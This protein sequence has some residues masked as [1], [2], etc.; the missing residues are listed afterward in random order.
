MN[1]TTIKEICQKIL[2]SDI[3]FD[4]GTQARVRTDIK[5][6]QA[7]IESMK[8]GVEFPPLDV[9]NDGTSPK[10]I[11]GDGFHRLQSHMSFRPNKPISCRVHFG[12]LEDAQ[13]FAITANKTHGLR[14][15]NEDKRKAVK[16]AL[17]HQKCRDEQMSSRA[18]AEAVGVHHDMVDRIRSELGSV[19]GFRQLNEKR[20]GKDGKSYPARRHRF[21]EPPEPDSNIRTNA[22]GK[23]VNT[24]GY[25]FRY[26]R[27]CDQCDL[28]S[29]ETGLCARDDSPQPSWT[30]ACDDWH[31]RNDEFAPDTEPAAQ[32]VKTNHVRE[33]R[34]T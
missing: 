16:M 20:V 32:K 27:R 10:Y 33:S 3:I 29:L 9:F 26:R 6:C 5:T 19:G 28:W 15:T 30:P 25:D 11:L 34:R 2:P 7:Y 14:R 23:T 8:D 1:D 24:K 31:K 12:T 22:D 4:A 21:N 18:I 17:L 13:W